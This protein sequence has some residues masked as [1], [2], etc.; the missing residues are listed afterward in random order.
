MR[1]G[2]SFPGTLPEKGF[3]A[4]VAGTFSPEEFKTEV[5]YVCA[6]QVTAAHIKA[7]MH[8]ARSE[9]LARSTQTS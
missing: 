4:V 3:T 2:T 8:D 6:W 7:F 9:A 1:P 5:E